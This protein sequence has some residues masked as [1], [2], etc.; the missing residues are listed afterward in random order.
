MTTLLL[1]RHGSTAWNASGR[2]QGTTDIALSPAG[3]RE[4]LLLRPLIEPWAPAAVVA[5]PLL[6]AATTARLLVGHEVATDA[7]LVEV[8]LGEWEGRTPAEIG[9]D[10][11]AWR[12][13]ELVPPGGEA[14]EAA[15]RRIRA[16]LDDAVGLGDPVLVV[17]HGG[18][19]RAALA[20]LVGLATR[21]IA[22]VPPASLTVVELAGGV[23]RLRSLGVVP[24]A[25]SAGAVRGRR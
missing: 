19:V 11:R 16:A 10:E 7:R 8:G 12:R 24:Q 23:P 13:G 6:R 25:D 15:T 5:S 22:P 14:A 9:D 21:H 1:V 20:S 2:L 3:E 4:A 17:T 18:V